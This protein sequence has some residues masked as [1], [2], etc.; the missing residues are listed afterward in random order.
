VNANLE[1]IIPCTIHIGRSLT[2]TFSF[3]IIAKSQTH[4]GSHGHSS[5]YPTKVNT[6]IRLIYTKNRKR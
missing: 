6:L 3:S 1:L 2:K 5:N 4:V